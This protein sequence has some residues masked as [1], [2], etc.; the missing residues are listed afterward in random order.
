MAGTWFSHCSLLFLEDFTMDEDQNPTMLRDLEIDF[1]KE[2]PDGFSVEGNYCFGYF[3]GN[4][5]EM[6]DLLVSFQALNST[7]YVL[8]ESHSKEKN[9][10]RFSQ[11]GI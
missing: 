10:N 6:D 4:R 5:A 9:H 11:T 3:E 8:T 1:L 2:H 7:C